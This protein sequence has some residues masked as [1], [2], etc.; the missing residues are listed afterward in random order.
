MKA[1]R[2]NISE[3]S[4]VKKVENVERIVSLKETVNT[5]VSTYI[6][7]KKACSGLEAKSDNETFALSIKNLD[8][9]VARLNNKA[10]RNDV[11]KALRAGKTVIIQEDEPTPIKE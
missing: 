6:A 9:K 10:S 8:K 3:S 1:S 4:E 7:F 11:L 5:V 2:R